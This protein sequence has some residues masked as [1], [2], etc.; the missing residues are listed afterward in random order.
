[1][2][3]AQMLAGGADS[4]SQAYFKD[5]DKYCEVIL[6]R[7]TRRVSCMRSGVIVLTLAI[8]TGAIF[9]SPSMDSWNWKNLHV[10]FGSSVLK[11]K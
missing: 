1:M 10:M 5:A 8:A 3:N 4:N 6:G 11:I 7:L 9:F 2:Q